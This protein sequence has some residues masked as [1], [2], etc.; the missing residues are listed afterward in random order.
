[1]NQIGFVVGI[2]CEREEV[3]ALN[4]VVTSFEAVL[5]YSKNAEKL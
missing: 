2:V 1:M 3:L 4:R 5:L